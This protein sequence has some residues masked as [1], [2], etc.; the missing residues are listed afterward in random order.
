MLHKSCASA[1]HQSPMNTDGTF[2]N[3][4]IS[5]DVHA[6]ALA[7]RS[8]L[9]EHFS[10]SGTVPFRGSFARGGF[11]DLSDVDLL[12]SVRTPLTA[13][14]F[15]DLELYLVRQFGPALV[16]YDPDFRED[17]AA[18]GIRFS[19]YR[20]PVFWRVDLVVESVIAAD[21]KWPSPFPQWPLGTSALMNLVWA[22]KCHCRGDARASE[23][24]NAA[25]DKLNLPP[26]DD[27]ASG[28]ETILLALGSRNDVDRQLLAGVVNAARQ[29][30]I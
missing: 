24:L 16:R 10:P 19:F 9:R 30:S 27:S 26:V 13:S 15:E 3:R 17:L 4:I 11:D 25:C 22:I 8:C 21:E 6:Y 18:Q 12:A 2:G 20:L 28:V 14:F 5:A 23:Y 7:V 1:Y 29:L